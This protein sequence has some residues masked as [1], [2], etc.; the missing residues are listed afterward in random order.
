M[1]GHYWEPITPSGGFKK[2]YWHNLSRKENNW[3]ED[4]ALQQLKETYQGSGCPDGTV[5]APQYARESTP[6]L[7]YWAQAWNQTR[8]KAKAAKETFILVCFRHP[9]LLNAGKMRASPSAREGIIPTAL[10]STVQTDYQLSCKRYC[11]SFSFFLNHILMEWKL[12][13]NIIMFLVCKRFTR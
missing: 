3:T 9:N 7:L 2:K 10:L 13:L 8:Q 6:S 1:G 4:A 11:K 5:Q 12:S